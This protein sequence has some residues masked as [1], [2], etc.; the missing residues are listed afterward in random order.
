MQTEGLLVTVDLKTVLA[1][2]SITWNQRAAPEGVTKITPER[3]VR[4]AYYE[5][6]GPGVMD[7]RSSRPII[8]DVGDKITLS[9][10][11]LKKVPVTVDGKKPEFGEDGAPVIGRLDVRGEEFQLTAERA[12]VSYANRHLEVEILPTSEFLQ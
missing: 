11:D 10:P 6:I 3:I 2:K 5:L 9:F 7:F 12:Q 4:T 1:L 8:I